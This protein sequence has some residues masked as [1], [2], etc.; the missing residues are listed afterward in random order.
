MGRTGHKDRRPGNNLGTIL[1][2]LNI[3][4]N[5]SNREDEVDSRD[6]QELGQTGHDDGGCEAEAEGGKNDS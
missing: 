3:P 1:G 2:S 6:T 5:S 4:S